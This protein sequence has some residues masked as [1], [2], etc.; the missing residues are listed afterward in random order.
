MNHISYTASGFIEKY[1]DHFIANNYEAISLMYNQN[2]C[3]VAKDTS[4]F[5]KDK[6]DV[7]YYYKKL[8]L[9]LKIKR[10]KYTKI[11]S[12]KEKKISEG[13][14]PNIVYSVFLEGQR[15]N[16]NEE[17]M[18]KLSCIYIL[19]KMGSNY[20]IAFVKCV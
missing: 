15:Y 16:D 14:W 1:L 5:F 18:N 8:F 2:S 20:K 7:I 19:E 17:K 11:L 3:I 9:A 10:Y 6:L 13:Y 12:L 4:Y